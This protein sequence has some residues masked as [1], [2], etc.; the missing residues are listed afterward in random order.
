M[1]KV[2]KWKYLCLLL[3]S[4][5][6]FG[7]NF[8]E[9]TPESFMRGLD[10]LYAGY[11]SDPDRA[12]TRYLTGLSHLASGL[13]DHPKT[14]ALM[15]AFEEQKAASQCESQGDCDHILK[16][17][18]REFLSDFG[19]DRSKIFA[20]SASF[21][22]MR[23]MSGMR[24]HDHQA[25]GVMVIIKGELNSKNFDI[26][27]PRELTQVTLKKNKDVWFS[28]GE[29]SYFGTAKDNLHEIY[30]ADTGAI[31]LTI[32]TINYK[33]PFDFTSPEGYL[34]RS[35]TPTLSGSRQIYDAGWLESPSTKYW[36]LMRVILDKSGAIQS[37][38]RHQDTDEEP[39]EP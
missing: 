8:D 10:E 20:V 11:S 6:V 7:Y 17:L 14:K 35:D 25:N 16:E 31:F 32:E 5:V 15:D 37:L 19:L 29:V 2:K 4:N 33:K 12:E 28:E 24:L 39:Q 9:V 1:T 21:S 23:P 13:I 3:L 34:V 18:S 26:T 36:P 30:A 38:V 27:S 22:H